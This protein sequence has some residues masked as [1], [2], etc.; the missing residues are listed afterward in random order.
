MA[1]T[2]KLKDY[3]HI[4][5]ELVANAVIT[6]GMLIEEMSTG[7]VR[8]HA[9]SGQNVLPMFA[10]EDELQGNGINDDYAAADQV[11]CWIPTRGDQVW[12]IVADGAAAIVIG[13][14]LESS[15][16]GFLKLH[17]PVVESGEESSG[18][19]TT[20]YANPIVGY[21]LTA[22]DLS[23]SSGAEDSSALGYNKRIK[24]RIL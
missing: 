15:G 8:K 23:D 14:P 13:A 9:N 24:V 19:V 21:A 4:Q 2:I 3:L 18:N 17:T 16:D 10:V 20:F 1:N 7:K 6:P 11:Q 5:E 22:V 12:C